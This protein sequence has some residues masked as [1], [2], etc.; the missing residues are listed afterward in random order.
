MSKTYD[1]RTGGTIALVNAQSWFWTDPQQYKARQARVQIGNSWFRVTATPSW[2]LYDPGVPGLA[3]VGCPGPGSAPE[4]G[5]GNWRRQ[6]NGCSFAYPYNVRNATPVQTIRWKLNWSA[7][8]GETGQ[9]DDMLTSTSL[10]AF[11]VYEAQTLVV[12]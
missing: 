10:P 9:L 8:N 5:S 12:K 11:D 3:T 7:D 6:P 2:L 4:P 1:P